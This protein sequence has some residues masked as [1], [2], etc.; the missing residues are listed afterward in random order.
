MDSVAGV[1]G[2]VEPV[3]VLRALCGLCKGA[4]DAVRRHAVD[5][6]V[7]VPCVVQNCTDV[8]AHEVDAEHAHSFTS[9]LGHRHRAVRHDQRICRAPAGEL[10]PVRHIN[11]AGMG[12]VQ[13]CNNEL[14]APGG[15]GY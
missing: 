8:L 15:G 2:A 13:L 1:G 3:Q 5:R 11:T 4:P 9:S 6:D 7:G 10:P 12:R 14:H